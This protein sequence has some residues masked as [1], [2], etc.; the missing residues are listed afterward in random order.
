MANLFPSIFPYSDSP[1]MK[2][3]GMGSLLGVN[4][5]SQN[6]PKLIIVEYRG[7]SVI[8]VFCGCL[9][10]S[11]P[12]EEFFYDSGDAKHKYLVIAFYVCIK[13]HAEIYPIAFSDR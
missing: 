9:D 6:P 11:K 4:A 5:G 12:V 2:K 7:A 3:L 1:E 13:T 10:F 8:P